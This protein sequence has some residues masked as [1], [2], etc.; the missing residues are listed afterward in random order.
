MDRPDQSRT[1]TRVLSTLIALA[2]VPLGLLCKESQVAWV[3]AHLGGTLY[4]AFF[5]FLAR[6]VHPEGRRGSAAVLVTLATCGV[7]ALQLSDAAWLE[8]LRSTTPGALVLGSTFSWVDFPFY[9]LGGLFAPFI[10]TLVVGMEPEETP[11]AD[12]TPRG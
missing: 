2:L 7:E 12:E 9:V 6:S 11:R 8:A 3:A 4:V 10:D 5:Y 1:R